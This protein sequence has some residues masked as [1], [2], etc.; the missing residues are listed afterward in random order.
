MFLRKLQRRSL[1]KKSKSTEEDVGLDV[2]KQRIPWRSSGW[3]STLWLL[4]IWSLV[5][6]LRFQNPSRMAKR[7]KKMWKNKFQPTRVKGIPRMRM[8]SFK[9]DTCAPVTEKSMPSLDWN[10][11]E[12]S[13]T[14]LFRK[15][16]TSRILDKCIKTI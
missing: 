16:A 4:R 5:G 9:V 13:R 6:E 8:N 11:S 7:E 12:G 15:M 14:E 1:P 10:R 2:D 3:D